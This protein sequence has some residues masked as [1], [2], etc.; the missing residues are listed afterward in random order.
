MISAPIRQTAI[1]PS[2]HPMKVVVMG[3][4]LV[5][6]Y[7]DPEGGGWVEQLRRRSMTPGSVAP[8]IYNLGVR[9]DGVHRVAQRLDHE[10]HCRGE[11]LNRVPDLLV[12][13]V[14]VNDSARLGKADG[15]S[16]TD[17][18]SFQQTLEELLRRARRLCPVLFIGMTPVNEAAMPFMGALYYSH[19]DQQRYKAITQAA[20]QSLNIPYLD[21]LDVWL[22]R[23]EHWWQARLCP[24]GLHPNSLGY[25]SLLEDI[26]AWD[27][28]RQSLSL[29][30][31]AA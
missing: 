24:D 15:R 17:F 8:V 4:S 23:G 16:Y 12:L 7:G 28:F 6:G 25:R 18:D 20:C 30:Q 2:V 9:G 11:L 1:Q 29:T 22:E 19:R 21:V 3:D 27:V 26:L 31:A 5:Y 14:G 10:F 13:S